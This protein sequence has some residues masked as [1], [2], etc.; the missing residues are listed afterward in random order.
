MEVKNKILTAIIIAK[1]EEKRLPDCLRS[2]SWIE[3]KVLIDNGSTDS[4]AGLAKEFGVNVFSFIEGSFQ[5]LRNEGLKRAETSW[6]FYID[7]DE[8]VTPLLK[9]EIEKVVADAK[10]DYY[11][12]PRKN[13]ILGK[14]MKWG[15]WWPDYVKRLY[16]KER[17]KE[18]VGDVHEEPVIEGEPG[19]LKNALIH[20]K[21]ERLSEMVEKTNL[22]S[23]IEAKMIFTAGHPKMSWWRFFRIMISELYLRLI[24]LQGFRD[25]VEGVIYSIYQCWSKF[26]TY[27]KLWE[28]Q[29]ELETK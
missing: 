16:K 6:V 17:L 21:H 22:R 4:T 11:V 24:R 1:D 23:E 26:L 19:Y 25:G 7:A 27:A 14:E 29:V 20:L 13:I 12:I 5:D 15:G 18:W 28:M 8:R 9:K 3:N 10:C 2:I